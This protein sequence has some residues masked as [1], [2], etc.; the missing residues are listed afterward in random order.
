MAE[1]QKNVHR[2]RRMWSPSQLVLFLK[3]RFAAWMEIHAGVCPTDSICAERQDDQMRQLVR[4]HSAKTAQQL[5]T[6]MRKTYQQARIIDLSSLAT[7]AANGSVAE[8]L[9]AA[10]VT[11]REFA[12][13]DVIYQAPLCNGS[14]YGVAN[15]LVKCGPVMGGS[16]CRYSVWEVT[17]SKTIRDSKL[18][19]LGCYAD[20]MADM[21]GEEC[22][23]VGIVQGQEAA[24]AG[25]VHYFATE[26]VVQPFRKVFKEFLDFERSYYTTG[27]MPDPG[28]AALA[29]HGRWA[30]LAL[31]LLQERD[32]VRVLSRMTRQQRDRL[33]HAGLGTVVAVAAASAED[34]TRAG[35]GAKVAERLVREARLRCKSASQGS[36]EWEVLPTAAAAMLQ[37]PPADDGDVFL[38]LEGDPFAGFQY[39]IGISTRSE[40]YHDWWSHSE[41]AQRDAL[42]G[43]VN[44][45]AERKHTYPDLHVYHYGSY[46]RSSLHQLTGISS[47]CAKLVSSILGAENCEESLLIDLLPVV[48]ASV[49]ISSGG[50]GLKQMEKV[51]SHGRLATITD[52]ASS[53]VAYETWRNGPDGQTWEDSEQLRGIRNYNREDCFS[54]MRLE[55]WLRS[56]CASRDVAMGEATHG[57]ARTV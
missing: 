35:L 26:D 24:A 18:L 1:R 5:L 17:S 9:A 54:L 15:F 48:R 29:D 36:L 2:R 10:A 52:A 13:A 12:S 28:K 41:M 11:T 37:L 57:H 44:F 47:R 8:K 19:H 30:P 56:T 25:H 49:C 6:W 20:L 22:D 46:D 40:D 34:L 39:L 51:C 4:S 38:D 3:S 16:T 45:L 31:R 32:D 55:A 23:K 50:Y 7:A 14:V 42:E 27:V 43:L 33:Q 53:V 21:L